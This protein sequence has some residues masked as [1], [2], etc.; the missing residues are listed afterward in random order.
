MGGRAEDGLTTTRAPP[1]PT[2]SSSGPGGWDGRGEAGEK[3]VTATLPCCGRP[4]GDDAPV[5][6]LAAPAIRQR[7]APSPVVIGSFA[8]PRIFHPKFRIYRSPRRSAATGAPVRVRSHWTTPLVT[9]VRFLIIKLQT[10]RPL[11][12]TPRR[13]VREYVRN[14]K[15]T[16]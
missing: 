3:T 15:R 13:R 11:K 4:S 8:R 2:A 7:C 10:G 12:R 16:I 6:R 9:V 5:T 1:P 14:G